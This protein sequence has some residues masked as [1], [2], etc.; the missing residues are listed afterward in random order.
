[1]RE[2]RKA[3]LRESAP[4]TVHRVHPRLSPCKNGGCQGRWK[5]CVLR[6]ISGRGWLSAQHTVLARW[7]FSSLKPELSSPVLFLLEDSQAAGWLKLCTFPGLHA[8]F[9]LTACV[10][11]GAGAMWSQQSHAGTRHYPEEA[12]SITANRV[13]PRLGDTAFFTCYGAQKKGLRVSPGKTRVFGN[14]FERTTRQLRCVGHIVIPY[15]AAAAG[16]P[17]TVVP[18]RNGHI[19]CRQGALSALWPHSS[20]PNR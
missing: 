9:L 19:L 15:K 10:C 18:I 3:E 7:A 13:P 12:V 20:C 11:V 16:Q 14:T 8:E 6:G 2:P 4:L 17:L 1:M 5:H